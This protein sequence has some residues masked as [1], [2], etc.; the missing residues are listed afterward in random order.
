MKH[1]PIR[2]LLSVFLLFAPQAFAAEEKPQEA[3]PALQEKDVLPYLDQVIGWQRDIVELTPQGARETLL[4][5]A[6]RQNARKIL[7]SSF[8]FARAEAQVLSAPDTA[9][10]SV[11]DDRRK[12]ILN[13]MT[14]NARQL[15][16]LQTQLAAINRRL[17]TAA[18]SQ[19]TALRLERENMNGELKLAQAEKEL[20]GTVMDLFASGQD[21][22]EGDLT[23]KITRLSRAV[24]TEETIKEAKPLPMATTKE[25]SNEEFIQSN[26]IFGLISSMFTISNRIQTLA[27][28]ADHTEVVHRSTRDMIAALRTSLQAALAEGKKLANTPVTVKDAVNH[29]AAMDALVVHY[30]QL[31]AAII[32]LGQTSMRLDVSKRSLGE[33]AAVLQEQWNHVFQK[34]LFRLGILLIC[35]LIPLGIAEVGRRATR[36]YVQDARRKRQL[37]ILRQVLLGIVLLLVLVLNFVT[38]FGSLATFA[39]FLMAGLAVA[40]QTVLVSLTAHFFFFGRFG[41]RAGD[42]V[43]ISDV[44][45]D[46]VQVGMLRIYL[47]ELE[48]TEA[49]MRPTGKIVA[50]PNSVLFNN[51]S[52]FY[53]H[54]SG[55]GYA[56]REMNF[57]FASEDEYP[58]ART[59][60]MQ[61]F[62]E[63]YDEYREAIDQQHSTLER[64]TRLP[65]AAPTPREE[66]Q[67]TGQGLTS[68]IHYPILPSRAHEIQERITLR[69]AELFRHEGMYLSLGNP[70]QVQATAKK[71]PD[72]T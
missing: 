54:I 44:T 5:E 33:W 51:S 58:K 15:S 28:V 37:R 12:R 32:P 31:G 70:M 35:L 64:S 57:V 34:L 27:E 39:G 10:P 30:K 56:W 17:A 24:L 67:L 48:G 52:A 16:T 23:S 4:N 11:L 43:T 71:A 36:R 66:L 22:G 55:V 40:L 46:V 68:I 45:G 29:R 53:K 8:D 50:F 65:L 19:R 61:A 72:I 2:L 26:G 63:I 9:E 21:N 1:S 25:E 60:I 38:E 62:G 69:L 49:D 20:L 41:V 59:L 13:R 18:A 47:M 7:Q 3:V 14:E 6:L 42:R